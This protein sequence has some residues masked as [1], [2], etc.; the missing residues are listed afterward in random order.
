M[1]AFAKDVR[2][3]LRRLRRDPLFALVAVVTLA[4]GIGANVGIFSLLSG[5]VLRPL[6][7]AE[8]DRLVAVWPTQNFNKELAEGFEATESLDGVAGLSHWTMSLSGEGE[9]ELVDVGM[10][11][12]D[13][14]DVLG[15]RAAHGRTFLLEEEDPSV[16]DV[17]VL[18][19]GFWQRRFD[20]DPDVIGRVIPLEAHGQGT[21]RRVVGVLPADWR[22]PWREM[23]AWVPL[24]RPPRTVATDSSWYVN[25]VIARLAPGVGLDRASAEVRSL[26]ERYR[27]DF[28]GLFD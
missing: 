22:A 20:G 4:L 25:Q 3:A 24:H 16:S 27:A 11:G 14:F 2:L 23:D 18:T 21:A 26:A 17:V 8:P 10:V 9:P 7:Y 1:D 19:H 13:F 28:P 12:T 5:V 6:P 15:V